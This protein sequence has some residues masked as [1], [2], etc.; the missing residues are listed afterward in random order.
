MRLLLLRLGVWLCSDILFHLL[1]PLLLSVL[2]HERMLHTQDFSHQPPRGLP[3]P[4]RDHTAD[5]TAFHTRRKQTGRRRTVR[6]TSLSRACP[7]AARRFASAPLAQAEPLPHT[8]WP[9]SAR[10]G[11]DRPP[12]PPPARRK[13]TSPP[14]SKGGGFGKTTP[15]GVKAPEK[16]G[17]KGE[18]QAEYGV[19]LQAL[20]AKQLKAMLTDRGMETRGNRAQ[21][22]ERLLGGPILAGMRSEL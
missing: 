13:K 19:D 9:G 17:S 22:V 6:H 14:K 10:S 2:D 21:L 3:Q 15:P 18:L 20:K 16:K 1:H 4:V 5:H 8:G 7:F 11:I 12:P